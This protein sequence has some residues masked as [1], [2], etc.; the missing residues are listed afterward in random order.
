MISNEKFINKLKNQKIG[1]LYGG[2]SSEREI[3]ILTGNAVLSALKKMELNCCGIDV[4][5]NV[6]EKI[7]KEKI[8]IAYLAMHGQ[9]GEDG[10]LQGMLEILGVPYTGSGVVSSSISMNKDI[11][12]NLFKAASIATPEWDIIKKNELLSEIKYYPVVVKPI[13]CGSALGVMIVKNFKEFTKA[14][15]KA[16]E[17]SNEIIIEQFISGKEITVGVLDGKALPVIEIVPKGKFYDFKSKYQKGCSKHIIPTDIS[18]KVYNIAQSYA[19]KIYKLFR[20]RAVCRIDMIVDKN[21]KVWV[22][23]NNTIPGMTETSLLPDASCVEGYSFENLV[24][25][26]IESSIKDA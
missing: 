25:K 17:Y 6:A 16:F 8:D 9:G 12:K 20:C 18:E 3:S 10:T 14:A 21:N 1:V 5:K 7:K 2:W 26:I 13:S 24:L 4:D 15:K 19:E 22:L 11:S 23:E